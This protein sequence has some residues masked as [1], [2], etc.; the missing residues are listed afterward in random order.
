MGA[1]ALV[2][3]CPA[4]RKRVAPGAPALVAVLHAARGAVVAS[5]YNPLFLHNYSRHFPFHAVAPHRD[6]LRDVEEVL[7]PRRPLKLNRSVQE[8]GINLLEKLRERA[9]V[10]YGVHGHFRALVQLLGVRAFGAALLCLHFPELLKGLRVALAVP[11]QNPFKAVLFRRPNVPQVEVPVLLQL[12][13]FI[14]VPERI[15]DIVLVLRH[16][17]RDELRK[18]IVPVLFPQLVAFSYEIL[19]R[20]RDAAFL[21]QRAQLIR[22]RKVVEALAPEVIANRG[23]ARTIL[24]RNPDYNHPDPL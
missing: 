14:R 2:Q 8:Q 19:A 10:L 22:K 11:F 7:V 6:F 21:K 16:T 23:F 20:Y 5:G 4:L 18:V 9:A 1:Q 13:Y 12:P 17:F 3:F 15:N 24:S